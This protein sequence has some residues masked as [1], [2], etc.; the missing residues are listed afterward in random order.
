MFDNI[1]HQEMQIKT[2]PRH[3]YI[4]IK[5][6]KIKKKPILIISNACEIVKKLD[7]S[8]I[9][10]RN[11]NDTATQKICLAVSSKLNIYLP[12][13]PVLALLGIYPRKWKLMFIQKSMHE[14]S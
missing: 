3:H 6:A 10:G 14:Y 1:S 13:N 4:S 2:T 9:V 8:Y 11:V 7:L 5:M 12:Y